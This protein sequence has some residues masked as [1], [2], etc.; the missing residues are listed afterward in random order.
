MTRLCAADLERL[1]EGYFRAHAERF[2]FDT[3]ALRV[4]HVLNWGGFGAHSFRVSDGH[5]AL[6]VK[7]SADHQGM[8]RWLKVHD[9]LETEYHARPILEWLALPGTSLAGLI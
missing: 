8:R 2:P 5:R 7:L 4:E 9:H 1:L 6:H 3:E